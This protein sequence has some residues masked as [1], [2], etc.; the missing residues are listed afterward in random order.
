MRQLQPV[1][2]PRPLHARRASVV[3]RRP[4]A[5]LPLV[6]LHIDRAPGKSRK[7]RSISA[8]RY[9]LRKACECR[10]RHQTGGC[11]KDRRGRLQSLP[12]L[13]PQQP[14]P[15]RTRTRRQSLNAHHSSVHH[16][17]FQ[18][19]FQHSPNLAAHGS[20][21]PLQCF[22]DMRKSISIR[23]EHVVV[24]HGTPIIPLRSGEILY[25]Q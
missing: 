14:R 9:P 8:Q 13:C 10:P 23:I 25:S 17:G 15:V 19:T 18:P 4:D 2:S 21:S 5:G 12:S 11:A 7:L 1:T 16:C 3:C 20:E 24:E 22:G 6:L